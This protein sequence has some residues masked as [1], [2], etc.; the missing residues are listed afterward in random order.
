MQMIIYD[1]PEGIKRLVGAVVVRAARDAIRGDTESVEWLTSPGAELWIYQAG[2]TPE[3]VRRG[4]AVLENKPDTG[5][6]AI[7]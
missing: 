3:A 5:A 6:K 7:L 2:Y 4:L 1:I